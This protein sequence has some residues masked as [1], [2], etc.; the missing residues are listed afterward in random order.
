MSDSEQAENRTYAERPSGFY[1]LFSY[2]RIIAIGGAIGLVATLPFENTFQPAR[3]LLA[4]SIIFLYLGAFFW[5]CTPGGKALLGR[6]LDILIYPNPEDNSYIP[7][8]KHIPKRMRR[9]IITSTTLALIMVAIAIAFDFGP[10]R[11]LYVLLCLVLTVLIAWCLLRRREVLLA[12]HL[13]V[14]LAIAYFFLLQSDQG[15]EAIRTINEY[16]W[17]ARIGTYALWLGCCVMFSDMLLALATLS[18]RR[19]KQQDTSIEHRLV[20]MALGIL[21]FISATYASWWALEQ[22]EAGAVSHRIDWVVLAFWLLSGLFCA[23]IIGHDIF[24]HRKPPESGGAAD[25]AAIKGE[26]PTQSGD[27]TQPKD[28]TQPPGAI[29]LGISS[30]FFLGAA[31]LPTLFRYEMPPALFL[32]GWMG[33]TALFFFMIGNGGRFLGLPAVLLLLLWGGLLSAF[34]LNDK[35]DVPIP[36]AHRG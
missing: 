26:G 32:P 31:L 33:F 8:V 4:L 27:P 11:L 18:L 14:L 15:I 34:D 22:A 3:A 25:L 28:S 20:L 17:L 9:W 16:S 5:L 35:A 24:M 29:L 10:W 13:P 19:R 6:T 1:R 30:A 23:I 36:F 12:L 7:I 21:P 2:W